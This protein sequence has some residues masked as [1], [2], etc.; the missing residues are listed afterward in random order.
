MAIVMLGLWFTG[1]ALLEA[2]TPIRAAPK[3]ATFA[4]FSAIMGAALVASTCAILIGARIRGVEPCPH[5]PCPW[6][7]IH[8]ER[9]RW[10]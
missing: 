9:K 5:D 2:F 4:D 8:S 6:P 7:A 1:M 10:W 3:D